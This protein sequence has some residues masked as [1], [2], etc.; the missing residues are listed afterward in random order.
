MH[1]RETEYQYRYSFFC[2]YLA[3]DSGRDQNLIP[4]HRPS[5]LD[6]RQQP[7]RHTFRAMSGFVMPV[8]IR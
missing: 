8:R 4:T 6:Q 1:A 2:L 3:S 5:P 7:V